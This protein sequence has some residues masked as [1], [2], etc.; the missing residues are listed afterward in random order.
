MR[1]HAVQK[2]LAFMYVLPSEGF[3]EKKWPTASSS[4]WATP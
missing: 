4:K 1:Y 2:K 3:P